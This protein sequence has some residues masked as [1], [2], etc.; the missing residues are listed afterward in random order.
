MSSVEEITNNFID[1]FDNYKNSCPD[2]GVLTSEFHEAWEKL[3]SARKLYRQTLSTEQLI[4][5]QT[6]WDMLESTHTNRVSAYN[7]VIE[8]K[9]NYEQAQLKFKQHE[10]LEKLKENLEFAKLDLLEEEEKLKLA[11]VILAEEERKLE[12]LKQAEREII[13]EKIKIEVLEDY[14]NELKIYIEKG[15]Y[16]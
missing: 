3:K 10:D 12:K 6:G 5:E 4:A 15:N 9:Q 2:D 11:K 7:E 8:A 14:I 16:D 1:C 13:E